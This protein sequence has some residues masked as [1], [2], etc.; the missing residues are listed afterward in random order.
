MAYSSKLT[1]DG[2]DYNVQDCDYEFSQAVDLNGKP[3]AYPRG[4]LINFT[5]ITPIGTVFH[6]WMFDISEVKDG[7]FIFLISDG[8]QQTIK[9]VA[10]QKAHCIRL[11]EN[12]NNYTATHMTMKVTISAGIISFNDGTAVYT[13]NELLEFIATERQRSAAGY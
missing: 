1:L 9:K 7:E 5:V 6:K 13:N 12:F 2:K 8:T 3:C 4:G 11:A 10:F